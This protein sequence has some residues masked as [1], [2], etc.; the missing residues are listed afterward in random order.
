MLVHFGVHFE[1]PN[2]SKNGTE[3]KL[4]F[5]RF[6]APLEIRE[7]GSQGLIGGGNQSHRINVS[8]YQGFKD[9]WYLSVN[10]TRTLGDNRLRFYAF[11]RFYQR[12]LLTRGVFCYIWPRAWPQGALRASSHPSCRGNHSMYI[13]TYLRVA[14]GGGV[15]AVCPCGGSLGQGLKS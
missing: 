8:T 11:H 10:I 3:N 6:G 5:K 4:I 7:P 2:R 12:P 14:V 9:S 15:S 13:S 1:V